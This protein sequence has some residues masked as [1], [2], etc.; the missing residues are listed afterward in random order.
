MGA[1]WLALVWCGGRGERGVQ[2][3]M[4]GAVGERVWGSVGVVR[5]VDVACVVGSVGAVQWV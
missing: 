1:V 2:R 5:W 3:D 4:C